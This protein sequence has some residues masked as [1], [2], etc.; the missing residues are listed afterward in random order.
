MSGPPNFLDCR[1]PR[2]FTMPPG[3]DFLKSLAHGVRAALDET[4]PYA[5]SDAMILAP[6]RRAGR[7]LGDAFV[8]AHG[9]DGALLLPRIRAIGDVDADEPPFEPGAIA[10][11]SPRALSSGQRLFDL[12]ALVRA[13]LLASGQNAAIAICLAEAEALAQLIDEAQTEEI[14][15]FDLAE[16][17][18]SIRLAGQPEH[19]Q[20]AALFLDIVMRH[21]PEHLRASGASDLAAHRSFVLRALAERWQQEPPSHMV[22]AAG[23]TGSVPATAEL[24]KVVSGLPQGAVILPGLDKNLSDKDWQGVQESPGHPQ[25]G[26]ARLL[27]HMGL[28][29]ADV[30]RWPGA[31][32]HTG[33]RRRQ[34]LVNEALLPAQVTA[35]WNERLKRLA[36][37]ESLQPAVLVREG[38]AGLSLI[39]A[40]NEEEEALALALAIRR[41]LDDPEKT[42][43]LVTP[44]RALAGRVRAALWRWHIDIDDSAGTPLSTVGVGVFLDLVATCAAEPSDPVA[45]AS[46]L[47]SK[48][49]QLGLATEQ[50]HW[51]AQNL[52]A[53]YLRGV[54]RYSAIEDLCR[55]IKTAEQKDDGLNDVE[56]DQLVAFTVILQNALL[57]FAD[58]D[59]APVAN[60][61][62]AHIRAAQILAQSHERSGDDRLWCGAAGA[63]AASLLRT[64]LDDAGAL[65]DVSAR[66]YGYIFAKLAQQ[67]PIR[68]EA[69]QHTRARILG[70]LEA[71]MIS[72]DLII[73][74]GLNEGTWPAHP[75]Q[76]PFLPRELR[77][78]LG[79]PDPERRLG[80]SAHDFAQHA[81][82]AEVLLSRAKRVGAEPAIASRWLWR[83]KTLIRCAA[84]SEDEASTML[85]PD[86]DYCAL[87]RALDRVPPED[88][89]PAKPPQP[90]PPVNKRPRSL[91]VTRIKRLIRNPYGVYAQYILN[92]K[93]LDPLGA[94]PGPR[95]RGN[96]IH[97]ALEGFM[98]GDIPPD[99]PKAL[100][101]FTGLTVD[102]LQEQGFAEH[103]IPAE[104]AR[105][106]RAAVWVLDWEC[107]RRA[108]GWQPVMLE[109]KGT[110]TLKT[111]G[112]DFVINAKADRLDQC[113][114]D[115]AVLDY[116]TGAPPSLKEVYAGFDPQLPLEA[117]ILEGA[118]FA[119]DSKTVRGTAQSLEY[120]KISGGNPPGE[121]RALE[122]SSKRSLGQYV[123]AA[124]FQQRALDDLQRL[125]VWF[126]TPDNAYL[127]Q[128]RAKYT[129]T[130]SD[131][132]L[133]ARRAEWAATAEDDGGEL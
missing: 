85:A 110:L 17:K 14:K 5:L 8:Q 40:E 2:V 39:E 27:Q 66:E 106:K 51:C 30:Q 117:A 55:A 63:S 88:V 52:E 91:Y 24:L 13:R 74:G 33:A 107:K 37:N 102:A 19:V 111:P 56:R 115:F 114:A 127:C 80:L 128:P 70:P 73:L 7:A 18:F 67:R 29:R 83:L 38:L 50:A 86:M 62:E 12:A 94:V 112:K 31:T 10:L 109:G 60:W 54:R 23:S 11:Q 25:F 32:E 58:L 42:V 44:D 123:S 76:D 59:N 121:R 133:L 78:K 46:L 15:T 65:G 99:D 64:L 77:I 120:V 68:P 61:A 16:E 113:G 82:K 116:K 34:R 22:I 49:S 97:N 103:Q 48:L 92:I 47:G 124:E 130:Y 101:M 21:W 69:M 1:G 26:M 36:K 72:A 125:I 6:T 118:G 95:E 81:S 4:S 9:D 28:G 89:T 41:T 129:D 100:P 131:Y 71:R 45:L 57:C 43:M 87:A 35:D 84:Q 90:K 122:A 96:A 126:D 98:R 119:R 75:A 3:A 79:L 132:D 105:W 93:P 104:R 20:R 108:E 53:H